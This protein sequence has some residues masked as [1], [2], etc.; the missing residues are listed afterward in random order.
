MDHET[1]LTE[2]QPHT[3]YLDP[4]SGVGDNVLTLGNGP[5]GR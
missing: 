3:L 1:T 2:G 4:V 5:L